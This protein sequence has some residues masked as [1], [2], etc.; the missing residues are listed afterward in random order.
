MKPQVRALL[1]S[2]ASSFPAIEVTE[3]QRH[4]RKQRVLA[5][6]ASTWRYACRPGAMVVMDDQHR[7]P[8]LRAVERSGQHG[9][10]HAVSR[11][12]PGSIGPLPQYEELVTESK[13]LGVALVAGS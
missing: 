5:G 13:D 3:R 10:D 8:E 1:R 11:C 12:E 6:S 2:G 7:T 9:Q 4:N